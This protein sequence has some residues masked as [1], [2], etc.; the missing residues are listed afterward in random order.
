MRAVWIADPRSPLALGRS[1]KYPMVAPNTSSAAKF[2]SAP[3]GAVRGFLFH[4]SDTMQIAARAEALVR[5]LAGKLGPDAEIIR[6]HDA[7]LAA[8]ATRITVELS[9]GSLFGGTKIVWLTSC[10]L[11]AQRRWP[12][13]PKPRSKAVIWSCKRRT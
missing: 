2:L 9:T 6:L 1:S 5:M 11:K 10:P 3:P 8:D 7:D 12:P 4:G 13:S